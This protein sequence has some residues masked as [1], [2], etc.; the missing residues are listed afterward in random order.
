MPFSPSS[1]RPAISALLYAALITGGCTKPETSIASVV[2]AAD[3][4][5]KPAGRAGRGG[6]GQKQPVEVTPIARRDLSETL[7]VV[8]SLAPNETATIRPEMSGLIRSIH[9]LE[10]QPV[11]KGDLLAKIDDSELKAQLAQTQARH[12]LAKLNLERAELLRQTQSNTQSDV[13]RARSEFTAAQA[14]IDL[15]K[16]R[17]ART[18]IRAPFDG[19]VEA[20][21]LSPGDYVN[22][23]AVITT[24]NDLTRLK[25]EF[26]VPERYLAKVKRGTPFTVKSTTAESDATADGDV[27]FVNSV[28]ERT[29][30]SSEVK[31]FLKKSATALKAG[32]FAVVEV[33]LEVRNGALTVPE[34]AIFVDQRGPQV[35]TV[36]E[37]K[38]EKIAAFV[39]VVTGLRARGVVEVRAA[40]GE[41]SG[42]EIVVAAGVGSLA[43]FQGAKLDPRPLRAEFQI[44]D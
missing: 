14:E 38:G 31:G 12:E 11:K 30:R 32:M 40:K 1:R 23:Q 9:F 26:Q 36:I 39:P 44:K 7:R 18:E 17:L 27:Y 22:T 20:R 21:T 41:L 35:V 8:G 3:G 33:V 10:G 2:P 19:V 5:S 25:V 29:T 43:L 42:K 6:G 34:G 28:I 13:D 16:I 24:I 15:I 37:V 4:K